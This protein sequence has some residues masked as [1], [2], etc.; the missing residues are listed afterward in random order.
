MIYPDTALSSFVICN[1]M[2]SPPI[3]NASENKREQQSEFIPLKV[4][5]QDLQRSECLFYPTNINIGLQQE[6]HQPSVDYG[7]MLTAGLSA[8]NGADVCGAIPLSDT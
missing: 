4:K 7:L 5:R 6:A 1:S 8:A 3:G 2:F